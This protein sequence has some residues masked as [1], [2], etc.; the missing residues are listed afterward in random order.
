MNIPEPAWLPE[1]TDDAGGG[2]KSVLEALV[3]GGSGLPTTGDEGPNGL[4][5]EPAENVPLGMFGV[6]LD[7]GKDERK[8]RVGS[9]GA[10][11]LDR[12]DVT[13]ELVDRDRE[14]D[15]EDARL[16]TML[17][18]WPRIPGRM[19]AAE[20]DNDALDVCINP[21]VAPNADGA[22]SVP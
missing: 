21:P 1:K 10:A 12:V 16:N 6:G 13:V 15:E 19:G 14:D 22:P 11:L 8:L 5:P 17:F 7:S 9:K 20:W 18:E 3:L 2:K 4:C